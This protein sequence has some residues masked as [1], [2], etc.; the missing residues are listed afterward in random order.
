MDNA[1]YSSLMIELLN[2]IRIRLVLLLSLLILTS[3]ISY[4][5]TDP[6]MQTLFQMVRQVVFI[7]PTEAF[8]T[9]LKIA[10]VL[11]LVMTLPALLY[12]IVNA[13]CA[14]T[15]GLSKGG[16]LSFAA[17]S[18]LLFLSGGIF[19][20]YIILPVALAFL[21]DFST[22]EMQPL[23]S[24]GKFVSFVLMTLLMFGL[25]FQLP[26][27][28]VLLAKLGILDATTLR[29]KRR[30]AILAIFIIAAVLTPSPDVLSQVLMAIPLFTLY[31]LGI[32]LTRFCKKAD[33]PKC[34]MP[35][36]QQTLYM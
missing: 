13:I 5:I 16:Q 12:I 10:L 26:V 18:Y 25:A 28:I 20:F 30:Y 4:F 21:L 11:G 14:K 7:S 17:G 27:I 8:V 33:D 3:S 31:E 35:P 29:R 24:A 6:V 23:L 22:L 2:K 19:C 36:D 9:K 1:T 15:G 34:E 32:Y